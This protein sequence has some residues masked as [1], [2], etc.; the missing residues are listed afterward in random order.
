[1]GPRLLARPCGPGTGV[2]WEGRAEGG[3]GLS[4]PSS[5]AILLIPLP[6][7]DSSS[8]LLSS[9]AAIRPGLWSSLLCCTPQLLHRNS[10][11]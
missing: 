5:S 3:G 10:L 9:S 1:M 6:H 2:P 4:Q 11:G 8:L 7:G